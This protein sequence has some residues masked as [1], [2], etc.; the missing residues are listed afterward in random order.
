MPE[1][2]I[3]TNGVIKGIRCVKTR[4]GTTDNVG[5][6][7]PENIAGSE[8]TIPCE[9]VISAIG[10]KPDTGCLKDESG[11]TFGILDNIIVNPVTLET[12]KQGVF[13]AGDVVS[14]GTTVIEAIAAGQ[15][16]A[17]SIHRQLRKQNPDYRF[18]LP[19]PRRRIEFY[20]VEEALENFKRPEEPLLN[21]KSRKTGFEEVVKRYP[22]KTAVKEAKRCLRCDLD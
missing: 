7:R 6:H 1:E 19:K 13:A 2:V 16:A 4:P 5:R 12:G 17:A 22:A 18:K 8:V 15:K 3:V 21:I 14:G 11:I 10:H 9:A 20:E